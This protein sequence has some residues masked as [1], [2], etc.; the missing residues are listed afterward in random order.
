MPGQSGSMSIIPAKQK[1]VRHMASV[2]WRSARIQ[3][4]GAQARAQMGYTEPQAP[5]GQG[6]AI[7]FSGLNKSR[8]A[9]AALHGQHCRGGKMRESVTTHAHSHTH[10]TAHI[11]G[12]SNVCNSNK[13]FSFTCVQT[14]IANIGSALPANAQQARPGQLVGLFAR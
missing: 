13:S 1:C 12:L 14:C 10:K 8:L 4:L 7:P 5:A 6:E 2:K 11:Y 3:H 9:W